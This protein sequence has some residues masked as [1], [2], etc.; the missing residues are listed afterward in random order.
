MTMR[1]LFMFVGVACV[2]H[3][4]ILS[5]EKVLALPDISPHA[6]IGVPLLLVGIGMLLID[7]GSTI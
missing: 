1:W 5:M 4:A 3:G 6:P 7:R 2:M